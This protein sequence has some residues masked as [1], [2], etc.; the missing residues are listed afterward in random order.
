M[1]LKVGDLRAGVSRGHVYL[2]TD[3]YLKVCDRR[4]GVSRGDVYLTQTCTLRCVIGGQASVGGM[5]T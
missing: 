5:Y 2:N 1:Y 4:A 3:M